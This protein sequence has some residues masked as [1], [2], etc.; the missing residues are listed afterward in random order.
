MSE[1]I[2]L[3]DART[4]AEMRATL[5]R[6]NISPAVAVVSEEAVAALA[7]LG[8]LPAHLRRGTMA[9]IPLG[10]RLALHTYGYAEPDDE[11]R[12][13]TLTEKGDQTA[14]YLAPAVTDTQGG[15]DEDRAAEFQRVVTYLATNMQEA[16]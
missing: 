4:Q 6:L 9:L 14:A 12:Y 2:D 13:W 3:L 7:L 1:L 11:D 16:A 15:I 5:E 10:V 8:T